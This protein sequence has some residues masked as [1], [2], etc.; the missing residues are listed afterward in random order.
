MTEAAHALDFEELLHLAI[1]ASDNNQT[2]LAI[3]Y[4]KRALEIS[5]DSG[6]A[7]YMLGSLHADI[8]LFERAI[9]EISKAVQFE[10]EIDTAHFQLGL[11]YLTSGKVDEAKDAWSKLDYLDETHYLHLF[12]TGLISLINDNFTDCIFKLQMGIKNNQINA[13]LNGDMLK[14]IHAAENAI[15]M[16]KI[17]TPN[18]TINI[19]D[20]NETD[21]AVGQTILSAYNNNLNS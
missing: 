10:P 5:P 19:G 14:M 9:E 1:Y 6:K 8:G 21:E 2:E 16:N 13:P 12:K 17:N 20:S 11:L 3:E 15:Q 7:L 18:E 4:L